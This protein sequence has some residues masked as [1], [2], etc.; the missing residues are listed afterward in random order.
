M[1]RPTENVTV[2]MPAET[3]ERL[4]RIA[5]RLDRSRSWVIN[6][7]IEHYLEVYDWQTARITERLAQAEDGGQFVP[8]EEAM[9]RL[10][11]KLSTP[12]KP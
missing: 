4:E 1:S 6:Q 2:R 10:E 5:A 12:P 9:Q 7:A 3:T 11:G 8:H